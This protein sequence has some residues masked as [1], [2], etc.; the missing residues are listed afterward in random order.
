MCSV[1]GR[2]S[3]LAFGM[4]AHKGTTHRM[5]KFKHHRAR[6]SNRMMAI[7][8]VLLIC[9]FIEIANNVALSIIAQSIEDNMGNK[10][11]SYLL[12][13]VWMVLLY[14][15]VYYRIHFIRKHTHVLARSLIHS[16][17]HQLHEQMSI[18][19]HHSCWVIVCIMFSLHHT[20]HN[21]TSINDEHYL[22]YFCALLQKI[23][24]VF[25]SVPLKRTPLNAQR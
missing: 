23:W 16:H 11:Y 15:F 7:W 21:I 8:N 6:N 4:F 19:L 9:Y 22:L 2:T 14:P 3:N 5:A 20:E 18:L 10:I 13:Y 1:N 17:I 24:A 25:D 12:M